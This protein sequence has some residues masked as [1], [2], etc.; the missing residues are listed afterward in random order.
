M[1]RQ[2]HIRVYGRPRTHP[3]P[4]LLAQVVILLGRY[5]HQQQQERQ[6]QRGGSATGRAESGEA[7]RSPR[8]RGKPAQAEPG[9]DGTPSRDSDGDEDA[10]RGPS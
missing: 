6:Q 5:L 2:F 1:G 3:D 9:S 7:A 4:A 8:H 10:G